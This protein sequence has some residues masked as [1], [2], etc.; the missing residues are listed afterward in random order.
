MCKSEDCLSPTVTRDLS[1]L[2]AQKFI[3]EMQQVDRQI[4]TEIR[5]PQNAYNKFHYIISIT[6]DNCF[7]YK[8]YTSGYINKKP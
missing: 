8:N 6:Y 7:P 3:D 5:E 4:V 1:H 2:N